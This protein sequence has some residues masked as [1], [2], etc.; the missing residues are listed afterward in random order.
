MLVPVLHCVYI[1]QM[2]TNVYYITTGAANTG[3][4]AFGMRTGTN[5]LLYQ[6]NGL[7]D[8]VALPDSA[9]IL[10]TSQLKHQVLSLSLP[11]IRITV[12]AGSG[13]SGYRDESNS[14]SQFQ[15]PYGL[16]VEGQTIFATDPSVGRVAIV[17]PA[18]C[19]NDFLE[20]LG[21]LYS[22][23]DV[24]VKHKQGEHTPLQG[25]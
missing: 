21:T 19:T 25:T 16:C 5:V 12:I 13:V 7:H 14:S 6:A 22:A 18:S 8:I 24:H 3:I 17:T 15:Q 1:I 9:N 4:C 23:F 20:C 10:F 2:I 11:D